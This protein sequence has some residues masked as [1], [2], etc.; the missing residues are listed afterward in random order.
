MGDEFESDG[1]DYRVTVS[2]L[3]IWA[4]AMEHVVLILRF[5][6][7]AMAPTGKSSSSHPHYPHVVLIS[8]SSPHPHC[9]H[10]ILVLV[11]ITFTS[12]SSSSSSAPR[13]VA[14]PMWVETAR[15]TLNFRMDKMRHDEAHGL[16]DIDE[17]L[18]KRAGRKEAKTVFLKYDTDGDGASCV[19]CTSFRGLSKDFALFSRLFRYLSWTFR[20]VRDYRDCFVTRLVAF[21]C[22]LCDFS[23]T[24][25]FL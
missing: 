9:P 3:W 13:L 15:E 22:D 6:L 5:A 18:Q 10:L 16:E 23:M 21:V 7:S 17:K 1:I 2:R 4:V 11:R 14:D 12:S 20:L 25:S 19:L 8:S 24:S